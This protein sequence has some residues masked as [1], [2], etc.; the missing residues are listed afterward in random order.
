MQVASSR[1]L[2]KRSNSETDLSPQD[3]QKLAN[4]VLSGGALYA[5]GAYN[6]SYAAVLDAHSRAMKSSAEFRKNRRRSP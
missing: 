6:S 5:G 3:M 2:Q 1:S 4:L